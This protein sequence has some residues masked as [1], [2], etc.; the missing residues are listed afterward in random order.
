MLH[1]ALAP[2]ETFAQFCVKTFKPQGHNETFISGGGVFPRP[3]RPLHSLLFPP[4][5]PL[6]SLYF[7]SLEVALQFQLS[8]LGSV[9]SYYREEER[10]LQPSDTFLD[11]KYTKKCVCGR[12]LHGRKHIF[13]VSRA[14][15]MCLMA[16]NVVVLVLNE[17]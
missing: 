9:I 7:P 6:L 4:L 13:G 12:A 8:D 3:F 2:L 16:A 1:A 15:R 11:S 5:P 17:I 14:Q 10:H